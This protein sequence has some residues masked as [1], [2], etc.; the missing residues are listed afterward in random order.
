ML[1]EEAC[2]WSKPAF[3]S[4]NC[5]CYGIDGMVKSWFLWND[6]LCCLC[7]CFRAAT[8]HNVDN[9]TAMLREWLKRA[10]H[11][12]HYVE[13]R[14]MEEPRWEMCF[15]DIFYCI[16]PLSHFHSFYILASSSCIRR[17]EQF[18][19]VCGTILIMSD[20]QCIWKLLC[21]FNL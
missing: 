16:C 10:Q 17:G 12:Y 2:F 20:E 19:M 9:T 11:V 14:P 13:W 3:C 15:K 8:D 5:G 6:I 1:K 18:K 21:T 4:L 7:L